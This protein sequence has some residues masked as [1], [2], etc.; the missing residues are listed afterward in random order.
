MKILFLSHTA[1]GGAFVVGSHHLSRAMARQGH[2][3]VH[4]SPPVTPAHLLQVRDAFVRRRALRWLRGGESLAGVAD[5]VPFSVLPW[6]IARRVSRTPYRLFADLARA[7]VRRLLRQHGMRTPDLILVDEPRLCGLLSQFPRARV[8]YR[9]TDLYAEIRG[10]ASIREAERQMV[11]RADAFIATSEPVAAHL[12]SLGA[13]EV[14]VV[15]NGVDVEHFLSTST[16]AQG[17]V[18]EH[19]G[20]VAIYA[21]ALDDRFGVESIRAAA[22]ARADVLFLL[23]GPGGPAVRSQLEGLQNVR[24]TGPIDFSELPAW[25]RRASV[26][27]LPLSDHPSNAGRSPMK[28]YEYAA[29]GLPVVASWTPELARRALPFVSLA[30]S[31]E[32]FARALDEVLAGPGDRGS[33]IELARAQAWPAKCAQVLAFAMQGAGVPR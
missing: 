13:S 1:A 10:D 3:V 23:A 9:P 14:L 8:V 15:E 28:L 21:G 25:F 27:L 33:C 18:L 26:G 32:A 30:K 29:S 5:V 6:G 11:A 22:T 17:P 7:S 24:F 19:A 2:A 31:P 20:P 12:R 4:L 16:S